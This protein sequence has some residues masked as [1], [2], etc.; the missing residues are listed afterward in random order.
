MPLIVFDVDDNIHWGRERACSLVV[1]ANLVAR[2]VLGSTP[3]GSEFK[4]GL[5][6]LEIKYCGAHASQSLN[7]KK[8]TWGTNY[9]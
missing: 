8:Y 6:F 7:S 5:E 3:C 4:T 2:Q 9:V 1:A